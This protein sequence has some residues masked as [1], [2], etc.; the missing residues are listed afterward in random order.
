ME[1]GD[2]VDVVRRK[3]EEFLGL[4]KIAILVLP[5]QQ[6]VLPL[7]HDECAVIPGRR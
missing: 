5:S 3:K 1:N 7:G 2:M 4:I 6:A